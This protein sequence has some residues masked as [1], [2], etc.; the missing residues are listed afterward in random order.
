MVTFIVLGWAPEGA[1]AI[2]SVADAIESPNRDQARGL[3][4]RIARTKLGQTAVATSEEVRI[5]LD[6]CEDVTSYEVDHIDFDHDP[7]RER[8][9]DHIGHL[10]TTLILARAKEVVR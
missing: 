6:V 10:H 1:S 4:E 7:E 2:V 3:F 9:L 5:A 8:Q